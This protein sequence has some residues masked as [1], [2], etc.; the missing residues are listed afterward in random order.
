MSCLEDL[1]PN[2]TVRGILPDSLVTVVH[3]EKLDADGLKYKRFGNVI[4]LQKEICAAL[5]KL[6]K[7]QFGISP[8]SDEDDI[9]R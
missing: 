8:S 6:F 7:E 3:V 4:E 2:A 5:V 9:A 1:Q